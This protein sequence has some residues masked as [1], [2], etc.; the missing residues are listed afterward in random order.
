MLYRS[1]SHVKS[2]ESFNFPKINE[3]L[4]Y[5]RNVKKTAS[6]NR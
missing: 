6:I 5:F 1:F 2:T 4:G 3:K